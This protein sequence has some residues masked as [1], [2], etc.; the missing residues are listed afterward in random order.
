VS[1]ESAL[2]SVRRDFSEKIEMHVSE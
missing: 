1:E 2:M